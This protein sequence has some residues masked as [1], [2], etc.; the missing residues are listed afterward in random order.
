MSDEPERPAPDEV[1][2]DLHPALT[3]FLMGHQS[4]ERAMAA[5]IADGGQ[6][7]HAWLLAGPAGI[8]KATLAYRFARRLLAGNGDGGRLGD[9]GRG[10]HTDP[11]NPV[12]SA[13]AS[14]GHPNLVRLRRTWDFEKKR[15]FTGIRIDEVRQ[16][17]RFLGQSAARAG[18]RVVIVD[19]ADDMT[20]S[21]ENALLKPLEEPPANTVFLLV[22]HRPGALLPT[23]RSRCR[24]LDL[25]APDSREALEVL[26]RLRP[27]I[28]E[29]EREMLLALADRSP[30]R[31]LR[32]AEAGGA[33][34]YRQLLEVLAGAPAIEKGAALRLAAL[35]DKGAEAERRFAILGDLMDGVLRRIVLAGG[36][37][38]DIAHPSEQ[39]AEL[40][41]RARGGSLEHW[42]ELCEN[43][44][45]LR[46]RTEAVN[47]N[48]KTVTLTLFSAFE[49][50]ARRAGL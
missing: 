2:A 35:T 6:L 27:D 32:L 43:L 4:A 41:R 22:A 29:S 33:E 7:H 49:D 39:E 36:G 17:T 21:A 20:R 14:G 34:I 15:W 10:L 48:R 25:R 44:R 50:A 1:D 18:R 24:R 37:A 9:D 40:A 26:R 11:E 38:A 23:I 46:E 5:A 31:A 8:G 28:D 13:V 16:L 3:P 30:G 42:F 45:H 47:L 19:A 12:F